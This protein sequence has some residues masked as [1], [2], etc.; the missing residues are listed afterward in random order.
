MDNCEPS[1]PLIRKLNKLS[2]SYVG[3]I[4]KVSIPFAVLSIFAI[5]SKASAKTLSERL[6][7]KGNVMNNPYAHS[8]T[9]DGL[10]FNENFNKAMELWNEIGSVIIKIIDV[11]NNLREETTY[12]SLKLLS[13][14]YE[15]ITNVVLQT[16]TFFFTS[17]FFKTNMM[18]FTFLSVGVFTS[19]TIFNAIK[20]IVG[21]K[22]TPFAKVIQRYVFA[23]VGMGFAPFLLE[24]GF[25][26]L[27]QIT[28][29]ISSLG[30]Y[31]ID[32]D[33]VLSKT[34]LSGLDSLALVGFDVLIIAMLIPVLLQNGRRWFDLL[35]LT[36]ITPFALSASVFD[37]T[38]HL[39]RQ[40]LQ[41]IQKI[42][43][44]QI[45]YAFFISMIGLFMF[46]TKDVVD[47]WGLLLKFMVIIGGLSRL[48]NPPMF[49]RRYMDED[50]STVID[51]F[52]KLVRMYSFNKINPLKRLSFRRK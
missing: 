41:G 50:K 11:Y 9:A 8:G 31:K 34:Q 7:E 52:G 10:S 33:T 43:G 45:V 39:F 24:K 20:Q 4:K 17:E 21:K 5:P 42:A 28:K 19:L 27:N 36:S 15:A 25:T 30:A 48:G 44:V 16:P 3:L 38:K 35:A 32:P 40:W 22:H 2:T 12:Y 1:E 29:A 14:C 49:L 26:L 6:W 46:A 13:W 47:G 37:G 51:M 18:N 23:V